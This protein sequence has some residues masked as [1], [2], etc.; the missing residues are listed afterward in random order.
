MFV[1][2]SLR[3]GHSNHGEMAGAVL[4]RA[5][6]RLFGFRRVLYESGYPAIHRHPTT[7][8]RGESYLVD[9]AHLAR[10]DDFEGCPEWYER[11]TVRLATGE[12][13]FVYGIPEERGARLP[14]LAHED[15]GDA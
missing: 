12:E 9:D 3:R 13:A 7:F 11:M 15:E 2:G 14:S 1:Y 6:A 10:L 4:E 8:V 5:D